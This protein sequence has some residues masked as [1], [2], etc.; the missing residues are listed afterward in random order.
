[1]KRSTLSTLRR[2]AASL[3]ALAALVV[4][5]GTAQAQLFVVHLNGYGPD[6]IVSEYNAN[7]GKPLNVSLITT[8]LNQPLGIAVMGSNLY[9]A[10]KGNGTIAQFTV[11]GQTVTSSDP[12]FISGV[13][14][15]AGLAATNNN[16]YVADFNS[17]LVTAYDTEGD[18]V[19]N[20][21]VVN[22]KPLK[23]TRPTGLAVQGNILYIAS[24]NGGPGLGT[25][26]T[27][28]AANGLVMNASFISGL[29]GPTGIAVQGNFL[30]ESNQD[31]TV[32]AYNING[33]NPATFAG[34]TP[35]FGNPTGIAILGSQNATIYV[36]DSIKGTV[37]SFGGNKSISITGLTFPSG[38]AVK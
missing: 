9:V 17:G 34:A 37:T 15:P 32:G 22:G 16:I 38:I 25:V 5:A 24:D 35:G 14:H 13:G 20:W 10:N 18:P 1:M 4:T 21:G 19:A 2:A 11:N 12:T 29:S 28:S 30:Y 3:F 27:Y 31:G 7:T 26:G 23:L 8:G 6:G 33:T 36:V